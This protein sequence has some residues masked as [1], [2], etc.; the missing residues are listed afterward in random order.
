MFG[1]GHPPGSFGN[2]TIV[3]LS[4]S[5]HAIVLLGLL[6]SATIVFRSG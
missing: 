6:Y 1:T 4:R 2:V 5:L 3:A